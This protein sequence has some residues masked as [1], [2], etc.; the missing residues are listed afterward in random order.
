[1][2]KQREEESTSSSSSSSNSSRSNSSS[3]LMPLKMSLKMLLKNS[4]HQK[5]P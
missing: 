2:Y 4:S 1:M 5:C 3:H